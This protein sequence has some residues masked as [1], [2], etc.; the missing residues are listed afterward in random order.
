MRNVGFLLTRLTLFDIN[1]A[2]CDRNYFTSFFIKLIHTFLGC[3]NCFSFNMPK[4]E[5]KKHY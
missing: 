2:Y 5:E 1:N 3:T 4:E